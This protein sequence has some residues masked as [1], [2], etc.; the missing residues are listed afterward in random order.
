MCMVKH[1][2]NRLVEEVVEGSASANEC[3][4]AYQKVSLDP[5]E[6]AKFHKE[7]IEEEK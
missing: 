4:G 6:V 3:T 7:Y 1:R 2:S 5:D